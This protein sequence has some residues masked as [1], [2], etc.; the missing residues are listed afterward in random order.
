MSNRAQRAIVFQREMSARL[1]ERSVRTKHGV[2]HFAGS[3][4]R[5]WD[6]NLLAIDLGAEA[7]AAEL[8]LEAEAVQ[9]AARLRHR[10]IAIDDDLGLR[11]AR[12]F[13][14]RG[15]TAH[16]YVV[17][18]LAGDLADV[19]LSAT[20]EVDADS[21]VPT[22]RE[23]I[24]AYTP[25]DETVRQLVV[26]QRDRSRAVE[27]RYF[28]ARA[29][30]RIAAY[31]ELF[32]ADGVGQV[33]SVMCL[34]EYRGRGLGKAVTGRAAAESVRAGHEL[35]FL[36]A[37]AGDWPRHMYGRLGFHEEARIWNFV[38]DGR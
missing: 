26:A 21:L 14:R 16:E 25:D 24:R 6:R 19:D 5:V 38:R 7:T 27:V 12:D 4:P 32:S 31:C 37:E 33:E 11:V 34:E 18:P 13:R 36:V 15:W 8:A 22:W 20:G 23:G 35:T 2:A 29:N 28:A 9:G 3:L 10:K 17:M 30:G 1:A